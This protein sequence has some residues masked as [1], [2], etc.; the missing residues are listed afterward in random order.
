MELVELEVLT[1]TEAI[2]AVFLWMLPFLANIRLL[3]NPNSA[4]GV[5]LFAFGF[6]AILF[7]TF[8]YTT[9]DYFHYKRIY[10]LCLIAGEAIHVENIYYWLINILPRSYTLWRLVLWGGAIII[11]LI[12][13]KRLKL[14][15]QL[16]GLVMTLVLLAYFPNMRQSLGFALM[17]LSLSFYYIPIPK[18]KTTS[19]LLCFIGLLACT[20]LHKSM[21]VYI[22]L[23]FVAFLPF[24]RWI[25]NVLLIIFPLL[26]A[27]IKIYSA[28]FLS[29]SFIEENTAEFGLLYLEMSN[30]TLTI[31]GWIQ[32]FVL[33][34]P[35]ILSVIYGLRNLYY[36]K[37]MISPI[38][39]LLVKMSFIYLYVGCLFWGQDLSAF[40]ANRFLDACY[41]PL[42]LLLTFYIGEH[43][44]VKELKTLR[45]IMYLF[46]ISNL[47]LFAYTIY[48]L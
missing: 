28:N 44:K 12:L 9:G 34:L 7:S 26:Y 47:Y 14:K 25:V 41:Y 30:Q 40:L 22:L 13:V 38:Q 10:E 4:K 18:F 3:N 31:W 2:V 23:A 8:A 45:R 24:S 21:I 48:K 16:A 11:W 36:K 27:S 39:E 42:S 29:A 20:Y 37:M 46:L 35:I 5:G 17:Y 43:L 32:T 19:Y 6:L 1:K 15:P 33:R